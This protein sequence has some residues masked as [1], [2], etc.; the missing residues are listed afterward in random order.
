MKLEIDVK[1]S[2]VAS[3]IELLKNYDF[4]KDIREIKNKSSIVKGLTKSFNEVKLYEQGKKDLKNVKDLI[5]ELRS[6]G[7]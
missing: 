3:F 4:V 1:D 5:N 7:Y 2:E 6:K